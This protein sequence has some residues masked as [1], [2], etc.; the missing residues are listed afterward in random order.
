[1][2]DYKAIVRRQSAPLA[3]RTLVPEEVSYS[4]SNDAV[5]VTRTVWTALRR[6]WRLALGIFTIVVL[7]VTAGTLLRPVNYRA[8]GLLEIRPENAEAV[9]VSTLF[10]PQRMAGDSLATQ[11]GI[12]QSVTL[13]ERVVAEGYIE[14]GNESWTAFLNP[15]RWIKG[16]QADDLQK[17]VQIFQEHLTVA[18]Q[19]GSRL[20]RISFDASDPKRAADVVNSVLKN[21]LLLRVEETDRSSEW[22]AKQRED[23]RAKLDASQRKLQAYVRQHGLQVLET[24]QGETENLVNDRLK[25]LH[26][27]LIEAQAARYAQQSAYEQVSRQGAGGSTSSVSTK[28]TDDLNVRLADLQR[29]AAGLSATF[30]DD[31]PR[32]QEVRKQIRAIEVAISEE[33]QA[34]VTR[35]QRDYQAAMR[36]ESLI[37]GA[38]DQQ[39]QTAQSL[40]SSSA[41]YASLKREVTTD[42]QFY[43]A[44]DQKLK[45][46]SITGALKATNAGVL[47]HAKPPREP[48]QSPLT[49]NLALGVVL[50]LI[51]GVGGALM[52]N[53]SDNRVHRVEDVDG[54]LGV[55]AV[56][57]IPNIPMVRAASRSLGRP[58]SRNGESVVWSGA[59]SGAGQRRWF[60]IGRG[61]QH[62]SVLAD[63]FA[64]LRSA[65]IFNQD[66]TK[67]RSLLIT[68]PGV[69]DGKTTVSVNLALS[70]ARL[71][72]KVLLIDADMRH[73]SVH[74]ALGIVVDSG[75]ATYLAGQGEWWTGVQNDVFPNLAV[76]P[77]G[78]DAAEPADLLANSRMR[79]L[80][81]E[82]TKAY[83]YVVI[84]S[85][86]LLPHLAD[87]RILAE[88][89]D[90]VLLT[91]RGGSTQRDV[92]L[93][94]VSQ[95]NRVLG[96]VVNGFDMGETP[97]YYRETWAANTGAGNITGY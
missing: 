86:P 74:E 71:G 6:Q 69:G 22:L 50:G 4:V 39:Q 89:A 11:I 94:A 3:P 18:P 92:A 19:E 12:L 32:L 27:Q 72:N 62:R 97:P 80:M 70:L 30:K 33:T 41:G 21:Y 5:M 40:E 46:V 26:G 36:R 83:D 55:R 56:A 35:T 63:A 13:A 45:E 8:T 75:L 60:Q 48:Y 73:P 51:G 82:A 90:G 81:A 38:L 1:M 31:Y 64:A 16:V 61:H 44:L 67:V 15:V 2:S 87:P 43:E 25:Q 78:M 96:I 84:D 20:V 79:E 93:R 42:A 29:E 68:S 66:S 95:L 49:L 59:S 52:R 14:D 37:Q 47:D 91:V 9:P 54:V 24:G 76:L 7:A 85:P 88:I 65:V 53:S 58:G 34:Q 23:A 57:V 28:V 77:A 10:G 17:K